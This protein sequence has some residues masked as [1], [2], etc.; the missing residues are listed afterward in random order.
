LFCSSAASALYTAR[1]STERDRAQREAAKAVKVSEMLMGLLTNADPYTVRTSGEEP[2]VRGLLD[3][4]AEQVPKELAGQPELQ[5]ELL[6]MMGRTYRRLGAYDK[7]QRLLEEALA[8][9]QK[10]FGAERQRRPDAG[11]S[12]VVLTERGLRRGKTQA[13]RCARDAAQALG[14]DHA[15]VAV[16]LV[17]LRTRLPG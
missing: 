4:V 6:T 12:R 3:S 9:G 10:V 7:A 13:R 17:E 8:S 5:A 11:L 16:T 14:P 1:L 15:D 2:T